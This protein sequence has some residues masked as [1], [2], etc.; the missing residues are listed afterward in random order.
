MTVAE[1]LARLLPLHYQRIV[2]LANDRQ[3]LLNDPSA[4]RWSDLARLFLFENT[5]EGFWYWWA[6]A[7]GDGLR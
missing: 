6:L 5:D 3:P 1:N 7:T 4:G 2:E